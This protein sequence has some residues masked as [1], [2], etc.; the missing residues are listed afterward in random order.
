MTNFTT[1]SKKYE[2]DS[3]VQKSASKIL[4]EMT[5]ITDGE[6]ILDLGCGTGHLTSILKQ[7]TSGQVIGVDP[8]S[9]MIAEAEAKFNKK[10]LSFRLIPAQDLDY[11]EAFDV[12]F[13]NSAFQWFKQ[14]L[15][16]LKNCYR[17]LKSQGRMAIQAPARH[18]YCPNFLEAID[19]VR[20]DPEIGSTFAGF[21]TP[22]F[23]LDSA[24][25]YQDLFEEAGFSVPRSFID[26]VVTKHSVEK[27]VAIFESGAAAGYL[28]EQH[29]PQRLNK[30]YI[31]SFRKIIRACFENQADLSE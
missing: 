29:Y 25:D 19:V 23:F 20:H 28:N 14:P 8:A 15:P 11:R 30:E 26:K 6:D 31:D 21:Q 18:C 10:D 2:K 4:L 13:C 17:A 24:R 9:G 1:I 3:V 12:I 27:V 16:I 7:R 22:W 5:A